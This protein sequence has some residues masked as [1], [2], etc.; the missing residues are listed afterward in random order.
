MRGHPP[1]FLGF[2]SFLSSFLGTRLARQVFLNGP[3]VERYRGA[4]RLI[5]PSRRSRRFRVT[6]PVPVWIESGRRRIS[7]RL[8]NLSA[9]GG[10]I[11]VLGPNWDRAGLR[12]TM[13]APLG[14]LELRAV[15][16]WNNRRLGAVLGLPEGAGL[17]FLPE[18]EV[19]TRVLDLMRALRDGGALAEVPSGV[20]RRLAM[21]G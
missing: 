10:F 3:R 5:I 21:V 6:V 12:L 20:H 19:L 9:H 1:P 16:V 4:R 8:H 2:G 7:G 13:E 18:R 15:T 11:E 17:A 14:G